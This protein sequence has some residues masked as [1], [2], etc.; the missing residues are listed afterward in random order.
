MVLPSAQAF[1]VN[2]IAHF[3]QVKGCE[4]EIGATIGDNSIQKDD[5]KE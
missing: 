2:H 5:V 1:K 3:L 4:L